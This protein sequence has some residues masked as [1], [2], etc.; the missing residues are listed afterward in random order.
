[1]DQQELKEQIARA[2]TEVESCKRNVE[3]WEST[4]RE[5]ERTARG[6]FPSSADKED[7][8]FAQRRLSE[9]RNVLREAEQQL[10][11]ARALES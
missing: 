4:V 6:F 5:R 11:K 10:E 3:S 9:D 2:K 1:M 8:S 7:L